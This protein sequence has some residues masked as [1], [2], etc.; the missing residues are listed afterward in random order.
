MAN[1]V[2]NVVHKTNPAGGRASFPVK[3]GVT[4]GDGALVMLKD[5]FLDHWDDTKDFPGLVVGGDFNSATGLLT[6]NK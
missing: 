2:L 4:L 3:S 6:E 1:P 5:G